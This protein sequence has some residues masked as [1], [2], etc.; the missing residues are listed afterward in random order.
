MRQL[1]LRVDGIIC[2]GCACDIETVLENVDGIASA[3]ASY[4]D[5]TVH[6]EYRPEEIEEKQVRDTI[7][8]LGLKIS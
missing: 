6:V 1:D 8:K 4:A 2:S 5:G 3:K 7:K